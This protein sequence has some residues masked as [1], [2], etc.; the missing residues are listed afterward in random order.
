MK[1]SVVW[2]LCVVP[3][4]AFVIKR[5]KSPFVYYVCH[6]DLAPINP[7]P[8]NVS[9]ELENVPRLRAFFYGLKTV[10]S[11]LLKED[12]QRLFEYLSPYWAG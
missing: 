8:V 12:F 10:R 9:R 11:H 1:V 6:N 4:D 2:V 5:Y 7:I 3:L